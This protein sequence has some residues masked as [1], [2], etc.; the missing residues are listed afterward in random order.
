MSQGKKAGSPEDKP[1]L[2]LGPSEHIQSELAKE[3]IEPSQ[4]TS[5]QLL[6]PQLSFLLHDLLLNKKKKKKR[7]SL[8]HQKS[9]N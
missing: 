7:V 1:R 9:K 5:S 6:L 8:K 2:V 4:K 3:L